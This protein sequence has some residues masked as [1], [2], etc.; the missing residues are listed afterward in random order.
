MIEIQRDDGEIVTVRSLETIRRLLDRGGITGSTLVRNQGESGFIPARDHPGIADVASLAGKPFTMP[1][2][3]RPTDSNIA[4]TRP[5][6]VSTRDPGVRP[7]G[8]TS[9]P[10]SAQKSS[11]P[12]VQPTPHPPQFP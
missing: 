7:F 8:V 11:V 6:D 5:T 1:Q 12:A 9:T 3:A 10:T 4:Q 2:P